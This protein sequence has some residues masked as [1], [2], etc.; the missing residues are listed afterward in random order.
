MTGELLKEGE[1][2][3]MLN[4]TYSY[5][6]DDSQKKHLDLPHLW[7]VTKIVLG[8]AVNITRQLRSGKF[9]GGGY[10][11]RHWK[12][13]TR[14]VLM[15]LMF[16]PRT[17]AQIFYNIEVG[18]MVGDVEPIA[19]N[20]DYLHKT[21]F[22]MFFKTEKEALEKVLSLR[23]DMELYQ[24]LGVEKYRQSVMTKIEKM[25]KTKLKL[26]ELAE[27]LSKK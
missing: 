9:V 17:K 18:T 5:I 22:L 25:N 7:K 3:F 10:T 4:L 6:W 23:D 14:D 13:D 16:S 24:R 12:A 1:T 21:P 8:N 27:K 2:Y 26:D 19:K 11:A 20:D 15:H